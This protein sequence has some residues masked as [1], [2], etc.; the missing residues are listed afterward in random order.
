MPIGI[1]YMKPY[2]CYAG[3]TIDVGAAQVVGPS[4]HWR[5]LPIVMP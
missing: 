3:I 1:A 4:P 5:W 2:S